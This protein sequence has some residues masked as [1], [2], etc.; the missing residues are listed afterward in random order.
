M[1]MQTAVEK[2]IIAH[3]IPD[4]V[5]SF[6]LHSLQDHLT[7]V[8]DLAGQFADD[9]G[10]ADWASL[11][12]LWHDL[13][14]YS[15]EFQV[16]IK[17][18]SGYDPT[19]HLEGQQGR[20]NHS[21]AGAIHAINKMGKRGRVLAY[22]IAGHHAGLADWHS[23]DA[24]LSSL[25]I[26]LN[27]AELLDRVVKQSPPDFIMSGVQPSSRPPGGAA[28]LWIR[29]LFSC[30]VDADFLDTEAFMAPGK[31]GL[32]SGGSYDLKSLKTKLDAHMSALSQNVKPSL[33]NTI[34]ADVLRQCQAKA[35]LAPGLFSL[36]V[37]TGGGKTL[38]SLSFALDHAVRHRKTRIIYAIPYTSI[39]EQTANIF[40]SVLGDAVIEHHS[41]LES[42]HETPQSRLACEN[43]DAPVVVTTNVQLFESLFAARTS[44]VRKL[45]NI[46]NSVI[47]LDEAQLLPPDFLK[48]ILQVINDLANHYK[49]TVVLTTATQPAFSPIQGIDF[50]LP[51]LKD[52]KEII[53]DPVALHQQLKRVELTV[54]ENLHQPQTWVEIAAELQEH[55]RVLCIVNRRADCRVLHSLMPPGTLHLSGLMCG[56]HRSR[57]IEQIKN[58]LQVDDTLRVI[59]TQLVEAGVDIDFPVVYRAL[60]GLDS[61]AQAA[62]RCNREGKLTSGKVVVF[63]PPKP[64]PR[65]HLRQAEEGGRQI[66]MEHLPDPLSPECFERFFRQ[67]FWKK[68]T[69]LDKFRIL[70][71]LKPDADMEFKFRTAAQN[72]KIIDD[73][74]QAPVIV[75]YANSHELIADLVEYGPDRQLLRRL[76]RFI[77]QIPR[78]LHKQLLSAEAIKEVHDGIYVQVDA[79][80]YDAE[81][82]FSTSDIGKHDP[83]SLIV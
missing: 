37:P 56:E 19:A 47:V 15:A 59:S 14:K 62:G 33:V 36:T 75:R 35:Q 23:A 78:S 22:L 52:V 81:L 53:D 68:G 60:A 9:F 32:R 28:H 25:A 83:E 55:R 21:S 79:G 74:L 4:G 45:H 26:R 17:R 34:R 12:G 10:N 73:T 31:S 41:N 65:G 58:R 16:H 18:E 54:P 39:I 70:E 42:D 8:S 2:E 61:I 76:Q 7:V 48:P 3:V 71:D 49:V 43:W 77:V 5:F 44:R 1:F 80:V 27:D 29:M 82:G 6:R 67:L 64:A 20:V 38:S 30:L 69:S 11:A 46:A 40:R 72:F 13:G 66:L 24:G 63:V 51:G 57:V 50:T